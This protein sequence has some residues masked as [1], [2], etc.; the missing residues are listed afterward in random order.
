MVKTVWAGVERE[1]NCSEVELAEALAMDNPIMFG[2][3]LG[4]VEDTGHAAGMAWAK[5]YD[6][7]LRGEE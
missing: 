7:M 4:M 5:E 6:K 1:V 2:C 3:W